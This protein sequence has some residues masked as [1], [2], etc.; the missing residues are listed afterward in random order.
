MTPEITPS[1]WARAK[2][3]LETAADLKGSEREEFL[4]QLSQVD[5]SVA[6]LVRELL[7]A[8]ESKPDLETLPLWEKR[9]HGPPKSRK[10]ELLNDRYEL[11]D[12]IGSGGSGE[13][14]CAFDRHRGIKVALKIVK[15]RIEGSVEANTSIVTLLRNELNTASLVTHRNVCR[16]FDISVPPNQTAGPLFITMELLPGEP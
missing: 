16:L 3:A 1:R 5:P 15:A 9:D 10:G 7:A 4:S 6:L 13:V 2:D 12:L 14:Y 11:L 8:D